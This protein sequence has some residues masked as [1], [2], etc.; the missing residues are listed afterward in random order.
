MI[1]F[2]HGVLLILCSLLCS[3]INNSPSD[4]EIKTFF[5]QHKQSLQDFIGFCEKHP[6][7]QWLD[8]NPDPYTQQYG[9]LSENEQKLLKQKSIQLRDMGIISIHCA[10]DGTM[11]GSPLIGLTI[12]LYTSA[13]V[14]KGF[15]YSTEIAV[16]IKE[17]VDSGEFIPLSENG[18]YMFIDRE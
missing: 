18:W 1:I 4:Q 16:G 11:E 2:K 6:M 15:D 12:L 13:R 3:C 5:A 17:R 7:I 14:A 10:R 8:G 9:K